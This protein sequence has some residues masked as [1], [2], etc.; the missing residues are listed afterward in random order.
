MAVL[1]FLILKEKIGQKEIIGILVATL[2]ILLLVSKGNF[3]SIGWLSS[4]GDW[5]ILLSAHTW[6]LYTV[7]TR[8][9]SRERHPLA[10]TFVVFTPVCVICLAN[11]I[12]TSRVATVTSLPLEPVIALVFLGILGTA[13]QWFWQEGVARL[14]AAKAGIFLYLEPLATTVLAVPLL[15]EQFGVLT[16]VGGLLVLG[17]V[18]W[19]QR[20]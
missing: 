15:K 1:S 7:V 16:A 14:G 3:A 10:V 6:A 19:A 5:L 8:N 9:L 17:G 12:A 2:G 13:A 11:M 4:T 18:W 20:H